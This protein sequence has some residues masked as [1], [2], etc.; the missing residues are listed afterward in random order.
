[1]IN[2]VERMMREA[3]VAKLEIMFSYLSRGI[4]EIDVKPQYPE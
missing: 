3:V 4:R 1:V 2:E